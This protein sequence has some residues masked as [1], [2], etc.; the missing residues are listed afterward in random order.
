MEEMIVM[1][2]VDLLTRTPT[3]KLE[4]FAVYPISVERS[5]YQR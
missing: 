4:M 3:E 2:E 1:A 5:V